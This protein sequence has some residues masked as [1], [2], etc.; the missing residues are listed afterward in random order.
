MKHIVLNIFTITKFFLCPVAASLLLLP[1]NVCV[2]FSLETYMLPVRLLSKSTLF[3][4]MLPAVPL[5]TVIHYVSP[6]TI[7]FIDQVYL[8]VYH[9]KWF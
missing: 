4:E 3:F 5:Q 8:K 9:L 7:N 1:K 6:I 2:A